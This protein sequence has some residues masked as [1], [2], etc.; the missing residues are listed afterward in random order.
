MT[1]YS[2]RDLALQP[3]QRADQLTQ[4]F[5]A[6]AARPVIRW[7]WLPA[8]ATVA[9]SYFA[10]GVDPAL[11]DMDGFAFVPKE[12]H[13]AMD[14][15]DVLIVTAHGA[16]MS[17]RLM[18][19]R[20]RNPKMLVLLWYWD[21]HLAEV[22]NLKCALY[23]DLV[24]YSHAYA[25]N[26]LHNPVSAMGVHLPACSA[27]WTGQEARQLL[28]EL[29][30]QPRSDQLLLNYVDYKFSWRSELLARLRQELQ[31]A[32]ALLMPADDRGRYFGKGPR[33]RLQEWVSHKCTLI[34]PVHRDLSTRVFDALLA[35]LVVIA[36]RFIND[37]DAVFPPDVQQQLGMVRVDDLEMPTIRAAI[38]Q[39]LRNFDEAGEAGAQARSRHILDGHLMQHRLKTM[40]TVCRKAG[41]PGLAV[42]LTCG[43]GHAMGLRFVTA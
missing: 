32:D 19:F 15:I 39:A 1:V 11:M 30:T 10:Q 40:L 21:N 35:G 9:L 38:E 33:E 43:E 12:E 16:D 7:S 23:A 3:C 24:F 42:R 34:L 4:S 14:D 36:P 22:N 8:P 28:D 29:S 17:E 18:A 13:S 27:Q 25:G 37:F 6:L 31:Q 41:E 5:Q 2:Y 20:Q 26:F